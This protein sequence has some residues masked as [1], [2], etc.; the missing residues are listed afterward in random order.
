MLS[1]NS[2]TKYPINISIFSQNLNQKI[3]QDPRTK[4]LLE[5]ID[6]KDNIGRYQYA[7]YTDMNEL[8]ENLFIPVFHT[9]FLGCSINNVVLESAQDYWLCDLFPQNKYYILHTKDDNHL[10]EQKN[11]S[12]IESIT[13]IGI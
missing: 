8:R 6:K 5:I 7:F 13:Q 2:S 1:I 3:F 9:M 12:V 4:Q 10:I 11:I